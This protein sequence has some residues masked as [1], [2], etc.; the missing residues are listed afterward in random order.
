MSWGRIHDSGPGGS[1]G[2]GSAESS[3]TSARLPWGF[4][5]KIIYL[6]NSLFSQVLGELLKVMA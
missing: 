1:C 3:S 6:S 5:S 4:L 2:V